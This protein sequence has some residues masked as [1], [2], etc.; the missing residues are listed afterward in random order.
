MAHVVLSVNR[1]FLDVLQQEKQTSE[2]FGKS[3]QP[4]SR[5]PERQ[6]EMA[7]RFPNWYWQQK[8]ADHYARC[9]ANKNCWSLV[10]CAAFFAAGALFGGIP[11]LFWIS[12]IF[13][14]MAV[15]GWI[16]SVV[17]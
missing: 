13:M 1:G 2:I 6:L 7:S 10:A 14:L 5:V 15:L 9:Q 11:K 4:V 16:A 3:H 17:E 8:N 12:G